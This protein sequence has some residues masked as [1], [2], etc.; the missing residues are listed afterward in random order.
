MSPSGDA[1]SSDAAAG[2]FADLGRPLRVVDLT[3]FYGEKAGGIRTYLDA[4][5]R[6]A[7]TEPGIDHTL[8]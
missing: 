5:M 1:H 2:T 4:K 3:A 7:R 6:W 8:V